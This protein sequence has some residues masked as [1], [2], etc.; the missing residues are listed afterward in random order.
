MEQQLPKGWKYRRLGDVARFVYGYPFGSSNFENKEHGVPLIRIRDLTIGETA[1]R[2]DGDFDKS[3]LVKNGEI[4]VG[5]DGEFNIVKWNGGDA[6]I[7]QR[8]CKIEVVSNELMQEYLYRVLGRILKTIEEK[9]PS[10]TVKH[11]S[12]KQL[13]AVR[14]PVPPLEEERRIVAILNEA[15]EIR[16]LSM[17]G[18]E[19]IDQLSPSIFIESFGDPVNNPKGWPVKRIGDLARD[20]RSIC[21][22]PFGSQLKI[23]EYVEEGIPVLGIDNVAVNRFVWAGPKNITR[24]KFGQLEAF[25]VKPGDVLVTRTGTVGRTCVVP[26]TLKEAVIGPNLLKVTLD[27][28]KMLPQFLSASLTHFPS[29]IKEIKKISPG[30]TVAVLN[31][32]NLKSLKVIVPPL[33]AQKEFVMAIERVEMIGQSQKQSKKEIEDLFNALVQMAFKGELAV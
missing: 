5:M 12:A 8:I 25:S 10:S 28:D 11:L 13:N 32:T 24:D 26:S 2:Y 6:L 21:C 9:T 18:E 19:L 14:L 7:N 1:T 20:N 16:K 27:T 31:T 29:M 33:L 17:T 4:L 30:A 3:Y 23:G 22:G 15:D